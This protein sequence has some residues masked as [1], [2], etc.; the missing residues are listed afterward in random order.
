MV[1][2]DQLEREIGVEHVSGSSVKHSLG[3]AGRSGRI[4]DEER[5][6]GVHLCGLAV[7][8]DVLGL[9]LFM[10]VAVPGWLHAHLVPGAGYHDHVL[11]RRAFIQRL[12]GVGLER[13]E[14]AAPNALVGGDDQAGLAVLDAVHEGLGRESAEDYGMDRPDARAGKHRDREL[15]DHGKIDRH[16]V[17]FLD[18]LLLE[19]VREPVDFEIKL[20]VGICL[21]LPA[22]RFPDDGRL[23]PRRRIDVAVQA[24]DRRVQFPALEPFDVRLVKIII[25]DLV[26]LLEPR[27]IILGHLGP[28]F[29]RLVGGP[30]VQVL[31]LF[32]A[33]DAGFLAELL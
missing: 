30:I 1:I 20:L 6:F 25:Q 15:R 17:A 33:S 19:H 29:F 22:V 31:V 4:Q 28:E 23:V 9:H 24:V 7:V 18:A 32:H 13:N 21:V 27:Q 14:P 3:L 8:R 11:D 16:P 26:P 5:V 10:P 12:V 2:E